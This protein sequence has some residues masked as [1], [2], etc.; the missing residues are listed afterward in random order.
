MDENRLRDLHDEVLDWRRKGIP[1]A[2]HGL[3]IAEWIA[4]GPPPP[5]SPPPW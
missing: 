1:A 4:S 5:P 3:T 2:A